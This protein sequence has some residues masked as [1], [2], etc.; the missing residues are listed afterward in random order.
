ML[1]GIPSTLAGGSAAVI[2][3][4][5]TP[6]STSKAVTATAAPAPSERGHLV[7]DQELPRVAESPGVAHAAGSRD[8]LTARTVSVDPGEQEG[9]QRRPRRVAPCQS[10]PTP[11]PVQKIPNDVSRKPT[12]YLNAFLGTLASCP[13][14]LG[15][16]S[17][18]LSGAAA[19][20]LRK[21]RP[22][23]I[24]PRGAVGAPGRADFDLDESH[25]SR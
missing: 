16:E 19:R 4:A 24:T 22:K 23:V 5:F 21:P 6:S 18:S 15:P 13:T 12:V 11:S 20:T 10:M 2:T 1:A 8:G 14:A 3:K 17:R 25:C 7:A 9:D